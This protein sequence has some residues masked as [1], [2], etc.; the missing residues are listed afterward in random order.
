MTQC[1]SARKNDLL[2]NGKQYSAEA[3][4]KL[5]ENHD[6]CSPLP[7]DLA[8]FLREWFSPERSLVVQTSGSTGVPKQ[9]YAEKERMRASARLTCSFLNLHAGDSILL[10]MPLKYIGAKMVVVRA[11]EWGLNLYTV[12]PSSHPLAELS[13]ATKPFLTFVAMTPAQVWS[14]LEN[15][16]ESQILRASQ[17]LIIG[18]SAIYPELAERLL[19]FPNSVWSTYGMTETLSHIA[20]RRLNGKEATEWYTPFSGV[21]LRLSP[22]ETLVISAPALC[23]KEIVTNDCAEI[24]EQGHFRILGRLDN[25]INS[26]GI[27]I[28][29]ESVEDQLRSVLSRPFQ[30]TATTDPHYGEKMVLLVEK[31]KK[32]NENTATQNQTTNVPE[33]QSSEEILEKCHKILPKYHCPKEVFLIDK[34]PYTGSGK[35]D[36]A[37]ARKLAEQLEQE[38]GKA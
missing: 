10:C 2:L 34:I 15:K 21:T 12:P 29:I 20:L 13:Q 33:D 3:L 31:D 6:A 32:S 38:R 11:L 18:G 16:A 5:I 19:D 35:P 28:Q 4:S 23:A 24:D 36:R 27:K 14:S 22:A 17:H 25:V 30:I 26:G 37:T 1:T 8:Q 9:F 7:C